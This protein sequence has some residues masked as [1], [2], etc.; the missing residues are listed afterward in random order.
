MRFHNCATLSVRSIVPCEFA[1][2]PPRTKVI[3]AVTGCF[4]CTV[5]YV[6]NP[7]SSRKQRNRKRIRAQLQLNLRDVVLRSPG[8]PQNKIL[9]HLATI[10][11]YV[12]SSH[13]SYGDQTRDGFL[14]ISSEMIRYIARDIRTRDP[15]PVDL[16]RADRAL[17][18]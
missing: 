10:A 7:E 4:H 16:I 14:D 17:A 11:K 5:D 18:H 8:I 13:C 1:R 9:R 2:S 3:A 12:P 15:L 6:T